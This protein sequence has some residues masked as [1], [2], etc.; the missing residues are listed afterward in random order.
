MPKTAPATNKI[1]FTLIELLVVISII[2]VLAVIAMVVYTGVQDKARKSKIMQDFKSMEKNIQISRTKHN[3]LLKDI[4]GHECS[5]CACS[6]K[7]TQTDTACIDRQV[8][9]YALITSAELPRDPWGGI[10][11]L[12]ENELEFG[13]D[14]CRRDAL[15]TAGADKIMGTDDDY[16]YRM[17]PHF[18]TAYTPFGS[19]FIGTDITNG[20]P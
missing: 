5:A 7:N 19:E 8:A 10:Y 13:S 18:C 1:G 20:F 14:D 12:D 4:T 11:G 3:K 2:A 16:Y 17:S 9:S 6:N 15:F